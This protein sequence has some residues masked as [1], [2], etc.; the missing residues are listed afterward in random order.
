MIFFFIE[1][2][3]D[4]WQKYQDSVTHYLMQNMNIKWQHSASLI[5]FLLPK[6]K[7]SKKF[8]L[9]IK[10]LKKND[11][12]IN[13][14][15]YKNKINNLKCTSN[16]AYFK[17]S[18]H[19]LISYNFYRKN[20]FYLCDNHNCFKNTKKKDNFQPVLLK[21]LILEFCL[22]TWIDLLA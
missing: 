18:F 9:P 11:V 22:N 14:I 3:I 8:I 7:I 16:F 13:V 4:N 10:K 15:I 20:I 2:D 21:P 12:W 6:P 1:N 17:Y 19:R 5:M